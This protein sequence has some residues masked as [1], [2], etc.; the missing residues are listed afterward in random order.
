MA[1]ENARP[2]AP[3]ETQNSR[4]FPEIF[5]SFYSATLQAPRRF[6]FK[7]RVLRRTEAAMIFHPPQEA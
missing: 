1:V 6:I 7:I 3:T 4:P 2:R 5:F